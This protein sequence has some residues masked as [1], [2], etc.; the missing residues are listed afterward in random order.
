MDSDNQCDNGGQLIAKN[1]I[2]FC[3][4]IYC[5]IIIYIYINGNTHILFC[6]FSC[7]HNC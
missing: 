2:Y 6:L 4:F 5:D 7:S 1:D 3:I